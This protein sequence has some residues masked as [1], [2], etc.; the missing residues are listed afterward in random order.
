MFF[1]WLALL[2]QYEG[3][4]FGRGNICMCAINRLQ[5]PQ[6]GNIIECTLSEAEARS[7]PFPPALLLLPLLSLF[8][9]YEL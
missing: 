8:G 2:L 7:N 3:A 5:S 1:S 9:L 4:Y 6:P